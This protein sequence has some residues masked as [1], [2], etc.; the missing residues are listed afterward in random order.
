MFA[1]VLD[2]MFCHVIT[3]DFAKE[4]LENVSSSVDQGETT[5]RKAEENSHP[6]ECLEYG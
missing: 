4:S 1:T 5:E 6:R 3:R 2:A